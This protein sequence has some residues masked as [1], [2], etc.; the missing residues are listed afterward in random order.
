MNKKKF[1]GLGVISHLR[2]GLPHKILLLIYNTF[3]LPYLTYCCIIWGLTYNTY[4]NK[5]FT[6]QKKAL[7]IISNLPTYCHTSPIF[8]N[9]GLLNIHQHIQYHALTFM[10]QQRNNFHPNLY[11]EKLIIANKYHTYNTRNSQSIGSAFIKLFT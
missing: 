4:I 10:C 1:K 3:I 9:L 2:N 7:R 5:I 11:E 8:K 6:N